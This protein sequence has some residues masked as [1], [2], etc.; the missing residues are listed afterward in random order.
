MESYAQPLAT[1]AATASRRR[2]RTRPADIGRGRAG[3][4]GCI[5]VPQLL[6]RGY[7]VLLLDRL[8]FGEEAL[9][10]FRDR[11][12]LIVADVPTSPKVRVKMSTA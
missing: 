6:D 12:E 4:V 9:A 2:H 8:Y 10:G 7:R 3:Y 5:L 11:I 1:S